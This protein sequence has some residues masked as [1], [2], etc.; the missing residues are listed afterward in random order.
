MP[1]YAYRCARCDHEFEV[2]QKMAD[3]QLKRCP[4]CR[5]MQ[6]RRVFHPVGIVLKGSGFYK[7]DSRTASSSGSGS[8]RSESKGDSK[9][10]SK[11]DSTTETKS[12]SGGESKSSDAKAD[13][14]GD[15][16]GD[17]KTKPDKKSK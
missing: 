17:S 8:S 12:A 10:E 15:S 2:V 13:H 9:S 3:P 7:T 14:K 6:L 11:T 1:T 5:S 4:A 16:K